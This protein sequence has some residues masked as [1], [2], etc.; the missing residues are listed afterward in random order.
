MDERHLKGDL[1]PDS[2]VEVIR[3]SHRYAVVPPSW[4]QGAEAPYE[5][6]NVRKRGAIPHVMDLYMLPDDW[7]TH[8]TQKCQCFYKQRQRAYEQQARYRNRPNSRQGTML[9]MLDLEH[10]IDT[11][12]ALPK[13]SRNNYLS[14]IAGRTFL[15]DCLMNE[16]LDPEEVW[17]QLMEAA[18]DAGLDTDEVIATLHSARGWAIDMEKSNE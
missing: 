11:L 1:G 17:T 6:Y 5:W 10:N 15:F 3:Y 14:R 12:T 13:G 2:H 8:L 4:H 18:L 16:V 9:A 7:Y